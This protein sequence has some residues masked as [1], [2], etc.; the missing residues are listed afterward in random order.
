IEF[1]SILPVIFYRIH[2]P[3]ILGYVIICDRYVLDTLVTLSYFLR[4]QKFVLGIFARLLVKLI[5][6]SSLLVLFDANTNIIILRKP[7]EPLNMELITYYRRMYSLL[8]KIYGLKTEKIDTT[9]V[10]IQYVQKKI[11]LL[12]GQVSTI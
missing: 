3:M 1:I 7:D 5:P 8:L 2:F 9:S 11:A 4:E 10:S 12:I 6:K